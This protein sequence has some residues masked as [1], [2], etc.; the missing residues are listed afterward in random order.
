MKRDQSAA[1]VSIPSS[2]PTVGTKRSV[3]DRI[4]ND[5]DSSLWRG[6]ELSNNKR[7]V[8]YSVRAYCSYGISPAVLDIM[9]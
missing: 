3:R 2:F 6:S 4:G 1:D 8:C 5:T 9:I 7:C